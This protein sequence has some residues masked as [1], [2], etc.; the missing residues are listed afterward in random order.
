[1]VA[2]LVLG[3]AGHWQKQASSSHYLFS[4]HLIPRVS[5]LSLSFCLASS[6]NQQSEEL[7]AV[8]IEAGC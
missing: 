2:V 8:Q 3:G 4:S 7:L 5:Q 6:M 1:M